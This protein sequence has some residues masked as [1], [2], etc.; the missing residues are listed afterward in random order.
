LGFYKNKLNLSPVFFFFPPQ[1]SK[2]SPGFLGW[3]E[4]GPGG[5]GGTPT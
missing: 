2:K 3:G 5:G 4:N 1:V